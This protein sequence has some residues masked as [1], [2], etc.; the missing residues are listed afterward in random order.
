[1]ILFYDSM[2]AC[3]EK[4]LMQQTLKGRRWLVF[5]TGFNMKTVLVLSQCNTIFC[6][7]LTIIVLRSS[8]KISISLQLTP[9]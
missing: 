1:M 6:R 3:I 2:I 4:V 8:I 7:L 9:Q 5:G